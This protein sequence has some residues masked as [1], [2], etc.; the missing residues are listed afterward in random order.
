MKRLL[1]NINTALAL[2][3][4]TFAVG[5]ATT[6]GGSDPIAA[7]YQGCTAARAAVQATNTA[8][9]NGQLRKP[10]AEK[11]YAGLAAMQ[12]GCNAALAALQAAPPVPAASGVK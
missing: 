7:T 3:L 12:A 9:V 5:C 6:T 10:D 1:F 11:A 4:L 8:V 2:V